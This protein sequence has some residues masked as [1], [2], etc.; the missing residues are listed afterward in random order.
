[1]CEYYGTPIC[2]LLAS[3]LDEYAHPNTLVHSLYNGPLCYYEAIAIQYSYEIR[4]GCD[5]G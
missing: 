5:Y 2:P 3:A 1:M 4:N